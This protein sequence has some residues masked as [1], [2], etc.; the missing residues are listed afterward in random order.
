MARKRVCACVYVCVDGVCVYGRVCGVS[1]RGRGYVRMRVCMR[2]HCA[3]HAAHRLDFVGP[4]IDAR[5][6]RRE[7]TDRAASRVQAVPELV[8]AALGLK[9]RRH[10]GRIVNVLGCAGVDGAAGTKRPGDDKLPRGN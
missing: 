7:R 4:L 5:A 8:E 3:P 2:A 9:R 10:D 1:K 6:K